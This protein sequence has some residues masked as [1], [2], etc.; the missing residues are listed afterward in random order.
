MP[1]CRRRRFSPTTCSNLVNLT[2][3]LDI[4]AW[5]ELFKRT[6]MLYSAIL[7]S[8]AMVSKYSV[9]LNIAVWCCVQPCMPRC[10]RRGRILQGL[11]F[12][13][14]GLR[15]RTPLLR[16]I[17]DYPYPGWQSVYDGTQHH[18]AGRLSSD[19]RCCTWLSP[20]QEVLVGV[21]DL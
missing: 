21:C 5:R 13:G 3:F 7:C 11:S 6:Y 2:S 8:E 12:G 20:P 9:Y 19:A 1:N 18:S 15:L 16:T 14:V 4:V 10:R 17:H